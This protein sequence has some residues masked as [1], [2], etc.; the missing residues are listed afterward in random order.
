MNLIK[1]KGV[2]CVLIFYYKVSIVRDIHGT[3][4]QRHNLN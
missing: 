4:S 3:A 2:A 1:R